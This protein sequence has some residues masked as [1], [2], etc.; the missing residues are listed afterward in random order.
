MLPVPNKPVARR[1]TVIHPK[2][3]HAGAAAVALAILACGCATRIAS[4]PSASEPAQARVAAVLDDF[5]RA[6]AHA[7]EARYFGHFAPEAVFL[8]TDATERW[9][10]AQFRAYAHPHF[11]SGKGWTYRAT[12][13]HITL[14]PDGRVAWFDETLAT[15]SYGPCRGSGVL[16]IIDGQWKIT[17]YNLS[18]PIPNDLAKTVA[19]L[20]RDRNR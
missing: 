16:R 17:Q 10:V 19:K 4:A 11:T 7:D 9:D 14:A 12:Q 18:I 20:I 1:Q 15:D 5:H 3:W 2:Y 6:A 13:R 8:G